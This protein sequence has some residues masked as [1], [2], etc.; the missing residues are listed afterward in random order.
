MRRKP[1]L[2][3][4]GVHWHPFRARWIGGFRGWVCSPPSQVVHP[5]IFWEVIFSESHGKN[6][7]KRGPV[8]F[9]V[10]PL[11]RFRRGRFGAAGNKHKTLVYSGWST[12]EFAVPLKRMRFETDKTRNPATKR[13]FW[14]TK[15]TDIRTLPFVWVVWF[16]SQNFGACFLLS[17]Q[18][19]TTKMASLPRWGMAMAKRSQPPL[20][21]GPI[22]T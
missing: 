16:L 6:F 18:M 22:V 20:L 19:I 4:P 21:D 17:T 11:C 14:L 1:T 12:Y 7:E 2:S 5:K 10:G 3:N 9:L 8:A 13:L 15:K